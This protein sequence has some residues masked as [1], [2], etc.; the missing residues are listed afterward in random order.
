M[1][2][3][4]LL[5]EI[6]HYAAQLTQ[7]QYFTFM[8]CLGTVLIFSYLYRRKFLEG[9][10][11]VQAW[12]SYEVRNRTGVLF[13]YNMLEQLCNKGWGTLTEDAVTIPNR[14]MAKCQPWEL[15]AL[16]LPPALPF[17][18]SIMGMIS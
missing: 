5:S 17:H 1:E 6:A 2:I 9:K 14:Y 18:V 13:S 10:R 8:Y 7:N 15:A 16:A 12:S 11:I 4:D 3:C